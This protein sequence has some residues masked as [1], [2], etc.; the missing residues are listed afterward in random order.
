MLI[1]SGLSGAGK[2]VALNALADI[3]YYCVDNLPAQLLLP[4]IT[5]FAKKHLQP[6]AVAIDARNTESIRY[7]SENLNHLK[8][9]TDITLLFLNASTH[10]LLRRFSE[11]RRPHPFNINE[12]KTQ[13][14][15]SISKERQLLSP[16]QLLAD[17]HLDTSNYNAGDLRQK[18]MHLLNQDA[19]PLHLSLLSFGFK[20]GLPRNSDFV[21]DARFLPNPHWVPEIRH[22]SGTQAPIIDWLNKQGQVAEFIDSTCDYLK[23]WLPKFIALGNRAYLTIAVGCTGGQHRSVYIIEQMAKRLKDDFKNID[24]EHRDMHPFI[25]EAL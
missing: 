7:L 16:L 10:S 23:I 8:K 12:D 5:D 17:I 15:K 9:E 13:L 25:P 19:P 4:F 11:S 2:S 24:I 14:E 3:G 20:H 18:I 21:F 6:V 1:L 22:F